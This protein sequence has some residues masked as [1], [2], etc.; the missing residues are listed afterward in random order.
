MTRVLHPNPNPYSSRASSPNPDPNP[1]PNPDPKPNPD[2]NP[3]PHQVPGVVHLRD[4][5][6]LRHREVPR[7]RVGAV[8][9]PRRRVRR[10]RRVRPLRP[11]LPPLPRTRTCTRTRTR[12]RT[13]TRT[14]TPRCAHFDPHCPATCGA[15]RLSGHVDDCSPPKELNAIQKLHLAPDSADCS[16][17][18]FCHGCPDWCGTQLAECPDAALE[19]WRYISL[20]LPISP[21]ISLY[22]LISPRCRPRAV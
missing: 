2:F 10:L 5:G 21:H 11:A 17:C 3:D 16:D 6:R 22:L 13:S 19:P 14:P 4:G 15:K 12:T 9:P 1:N 7:H 18:D 8:Q 20:Y